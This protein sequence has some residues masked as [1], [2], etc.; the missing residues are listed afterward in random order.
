MHP[1]TPARSPRSGDARLTPEQ[2][3]EVNRANA[4]K[5]TGPRTPEGKARSSANARRHGL[6][7]Q[8]SFMLDDDFNA[9]TEHAVRLILELKPVGAEEEQLVQFLIDTGWLIH[10]ANACEINSRTLD[11]DS[12]YSF[13]PGYR[14]SGREIVIAEIDS[15]R[16]DCAGAN[17][18]DFIGR[19]RVRLGNLYFRLRAQLRMLQNERRALA[20]EIRALK[21]E[22]GKNY[23]PELHG[24]IAA[25][26]FDLGQSGALKFYLKPAQLKAKIKKAKALATPAVPEL[27]AAP[28][29]NDMAKVS[30]EANPRSA[31]ESP[32]FSNLIPS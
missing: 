26:G 29:E 12:K 13:P 15:I 25:I 14:L 21:R 32:T 5:S 17:A 20:A 23:N 16:A 18:A 1:T 31:A 27:L 22:H 7:G 2:R 19:Q 28:V 3:A 6:T 4:A 9:Y 8:F 11:I 30:N 24:P 10:R